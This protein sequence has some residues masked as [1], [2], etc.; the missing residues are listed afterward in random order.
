MKPAYGFCLMAVFSVASPATSFLHNVKKSNAGAQNITKILN[1]LDK[2]Y[3]ILRGTYSSD[4]SPM[5]R[6]SYYRF[7]CGKITISEGLS[8]TNFTAL[9]SFENPRS[10]ADVTAKYL[11]RAFSSKGMW[12]TRNFMAVYKYY[13]APR[14]HIFVDLMFLLLSDYET[15]ALFGRQPSEECEIW[16]YG[17]P[18]KTWSPVGKT[19]CD[20]FRPMC[21]N[22]KIGTVSQQKMGIV[23]RPEV[24]I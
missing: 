24:R 2:T 9:V 11:L 14:E 7:R 22:K 23:S 18:N 20:D 12:P 1:R 16:Y 10:T 15:C 3:Y 8:P 5:I 13:P 17:K 4:E 19:V 21:A 6:Y